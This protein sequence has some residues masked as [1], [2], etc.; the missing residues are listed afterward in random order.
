LINFSALSLK[1]LPSALYA[2]TASSKT[3]GSIPLIAPATGAA[4]ATS[5]PG[6]ISSGTKSK[7]LFTWNF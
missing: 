2:L 4:K 3:C 1:T 7:N 5:G 6:A